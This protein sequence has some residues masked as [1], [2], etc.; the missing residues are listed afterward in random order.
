MSQSLNK[1]SYYIYDIYDI[2]TFCCNCTLVLACHSILSAMTQG[3]MDSW[4]QLSLEQMH[5]ATEL[6]GVRVGLGIM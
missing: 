4:Q 6:C 5:T 2:F 3:T 1:Y